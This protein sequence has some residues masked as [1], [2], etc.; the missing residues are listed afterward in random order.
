MTSEMFSLHESFGWGLEDFQWLTVNAMK[1]AFWPFD[2]RLEIINNV[3]KPGYQTLISQSG[4]NSKD[5]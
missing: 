1:S 4:L 3:I 5:A 2:E